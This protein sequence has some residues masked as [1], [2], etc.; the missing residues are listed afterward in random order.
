[1]TADIEKM[2]RQIMVHQDDR[3]FQQI[4][5]R[6]DAS[7]PLKAF[8]L[9]TI[10]YGTSCAPFLATRVLNQL[11]D[12][13]GKEY[14]LASQAV[15][16][17]FY[18]DD[19][20]T[21]ANSIEDMKEIAR[22]LI[23]LLDGAG[24]S[25]RKWSS[26][27]TA[28]IIDIPE[29]HWE[30]QPQL[31]L[32][33]SPSIKTLG[34]LWFPT[35]D[36]FGFNIPQ[37]STIE[38]VTKRVVLSEISQLFDPLGLVGPIVISAK[39]FIQRLWLEDLQWDDELPEE[40]RSWWLSFRVSIDVLQEI[41][42]PRWVLGTG[43]IDYQLHC[44]VD[45][46]EKGYGAWL[47]V[48]ASDSNGPKFSNLLIAKSRVSPK[49]GETMPRLELCAARLG[50]QLIDTILQTTTFAGT[51]FVVRFNHCS[52]LDSLTP[53]E[54]EDIRIQPYCRDSSTY[55]RLPVAVWSYSTQ[56][57]RLLIERTPAR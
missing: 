49:S 11:A 34:L 47:Y 17:D 4:L 15:K 55:P 31:E 6:N 26:N 19:L 50:C 28:C 57:C 7:E 35:A 8:Q 5:W 13:D 10:T 20:L 29:E 33:R 43:I 32:D 46:S 56:S 51:N 25:L 2:Y 22:Q 21:G 42:V 24:F 52:A 40:L 1:M 18:D 38:K 54:V 9:N 41:R 3:Q 30:R 48:V 16:R 39:M 23:E 36:V 53:V 45:A 14:P 37:L 44:F 12:D 27:D